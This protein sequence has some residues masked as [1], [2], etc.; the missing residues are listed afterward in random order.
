MRFFTNKGVIQKIVIVLIMLTLFNFTV[1]VVS[2]ASFGGKLMEPLIDFFGGICDIALGFMQ[3]YMMQVSR[4]KSIMIKQNDDYAQ[5]LSDEVTNNPSNTQVTVSSRTLSNG[6]FD[7]GE[8]LGGLVNIPNIMYSPEM[9]FSNKVAMLDVNFIHPNQNYQSIEGSGTVDSTAKKLQPIIASWY[10]A[11]RNIALVGLLSVLVY[12]G[13]KIVISSTA[14]EKAKYKERIVDWLVAVCILFVLHYIMSFTLVITEELTKML[15]SAQTIDVIVQNSSSTTEDGTSNNVAL[16]FKTTLMGYIRFMCQSDELFEMAGYMIMY[17]VLVIYTGMFTITY[18][19]RVLYMAF[20]TM[21][22]PL[23][24]LTYPLD[25]M[26]DGQAQAFNMWTKE[27]IFNALIQPIHLALYTMLIG[28][29][30]QLAVENPIYALVAM[31]F[32]I[33]AE[34]FIK[35]MFG[36]NKAKTPGTLGAVAGGAMVMNALKSFKPKDKS[37]ENSSD[38]N[39]RFAEDAGN[40]PDAF[41]GN[42]GEGS[43]NTEQE[44]DDNNNNMHDMTDEEREGIEPAGFMYQDDSGG[45]YG[46]DGNRVNDGRQS[47]ENQNNISMDDMTDEER[48]GIEPAGFMYQDDSG[49][50]YDTDG[51]R[52][53]DGRQSAATIT[54]RRL[55]RRDRFLASAEEFGRRRIRGAKRT[56]KKLW[57]N[58]FKYAGRAAGTVL[59]GM[60]GVAAGIASGDASKT[61]QYTATGVG[62]GAMGV[63]KVASNIDTLRKEEAEEIRDAVYGRNEEDKK[64][65]KKQKAEKR[66]K[67]MKLDENVIKQLRDA[68]EKNPDKWIADNK[69]IIQ[70]YFANGAK[71]MKTIYNVEKMRREN[72]DFGKG[73]VGN[74]P[75]DGAKKEY[76]FAL[77]K[78]SDKMG[79]N[80]GNTTYMRSYEK[81]MAENSDVGANAAKIISRDLKM[82]RK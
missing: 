50:I 47:E 69:D 78:Q 37:K 72:A 2:S 32:L 16:Q 7:W 10:N 17:A 22:A 20:L 23:V 6:W 38:D 59:G 1:P 48:E 53:N 73:V 40:I 77:A 33:P 63:G 81:S 75:N 43:G 28:S 79:N 5:T 19:K 12:T 4:S 54:G 25:K 30:M 44:N 39:V 82:T 8:D 21:I 62:A 35:E 65:R 52:V 49:G 80:I 31:G 34:K 76:A 71:D 15:S 27:Y 45:I 51:N 66:Y 70:E 67:D 13:I 68:G 26:N 55:T 18:L 56:A 58:K 42:G 3:K 61:A 60:A 57:K 14:T 9:I 46:T 24:A 11:F 41:I 29:S 74:N 36:L 64:L